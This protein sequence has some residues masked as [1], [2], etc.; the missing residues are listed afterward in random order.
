[1]F[2]FLMLS[3]FLLD[4]LFI[5]ILNVIPFPNPPPETLYPIPWPPASVRVCPH[6]LL[7]PCPHI[8]LHW[9]I[10]PSWD[11]GPLLSLM[12]DKAILCYIYSWSHGSLH[13]YS[14]VGGLYP[15]F[16]FKNKQWNILRKHHSYSMGNWNDYVFTVNW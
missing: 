6:L 7:P 8:P 4:I 2:F 11:Q 15:D 14:L 9:D 1:L 12:L 16:S 10:E 5:Y 3:Y 13:V